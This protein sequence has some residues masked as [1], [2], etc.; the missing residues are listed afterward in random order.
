[1][2]RFA[3]IPLLAVVAAGC[4][5]VNADVKADVTGRDYTGHLRHVVL[6]K[7]NDGVSADK[8]QAVI[9]AFRELPDKIDVIEHFEWGVEATSR[10]LNKGFTHGGVMIFKD[11]NALAVYRDHPA[12][13][14]FADMATPLMDEIFVYDYIARD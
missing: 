6:F 1:M 14:E 5:H 13:V 12:H 11:A 7:F 10:G 9:E 8:K 4:I 3:L 2:K